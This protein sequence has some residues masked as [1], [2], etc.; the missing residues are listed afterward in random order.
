ME[1]CEGSVESVGVREG[2][3]DVKERERE[4]DEFRTTLIPKRRRSKVV[5]DDLVSPYFGRWRH[6]DEIGI[7]ARSV[8]P[9]LRLQ[10]SRD[11]EMKTT[12][13][14]FGRGTSHL[15]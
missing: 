4:K 3:S 5:A 7:V 14:F 8:T 6:L 11:I 9:L 15:A 2:W 12:L 10:S 1:G 13:L